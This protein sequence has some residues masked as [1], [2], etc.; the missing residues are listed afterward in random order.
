MMLVSEASGTQSQLLV[1]G[2]GVDSSCTAGNSQVL[3][4]ILQ[5]TQTTVNIDSV[6][7]NG[8]VVNSTTSSGV[9]IELP[10]SFTAAVVGRYKQFVSNNSQYCTPVG[11]WSTL[12]GSLQLAH[13]LQDDSYF[14]HCLQQLFN[15]W[16]R[17]SVD[18]YNSKLSQDLLDRLVIRLP[19]H[20]LPASRHHDKRFLQR[21][22][23]VSPTHPANTVIFDGD[24]QYHLNCPSEATPA[25]VKAAA[26]DVTTSDDNCCSINRKLYTYC[27][28]KGYQ[29]EYVAS[30]RINDKFELTNIQVG[31]RREGMWYT[32]HSN[33][34]LNSVVIYCNG[35]RQGLWTEYHYDGSLCATGQY[36][37]D[38][39]QGLWSYYHGNGNLRRQGC[40]A[41]GKE[42]GEWLDY[43][44]DGTIA[45][46]GCYLDGLE[47]GVWRYYGKNGVVTKQGRYKHGKRSG[48]W[49]L[50][51]DNGNFSTY[52]DY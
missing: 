36:V 9:M 5:L 38:L 12:S 42:T 45:A 33:G 39:A 2:A 31:Q 14:E 35:K 3:R 37:D 27:V 32:Y 48:I 47:H 7:N 41:N 51:Q 29:A 50:Y 20:L 18:A 15:N 30:F 28:I 24:S 11:S 25:I 46:R 13:F 6:T 21:W 26:V 17:F 34:K 10:P 19:F 23:V 43:C 52:L 49:S 8:Q 16:F 1:L 40:Y 44:Y 4:D 22:L